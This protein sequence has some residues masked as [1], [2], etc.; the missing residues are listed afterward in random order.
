MWSSS[1]LCR[2]PVLQLQ[3]AG[4]TN[5]RLR[6][7]MDKMAERRAELEAQVAQLK[8]QVRGLHVYGVGWSEFWCELTTV[9]LL[10][11]QG[12]GTGMHGLAVRPMPRFPT[13][14]SIQEGYSGCSFP[15]IVL[16]WPSS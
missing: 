6:T 16:L 9:C 4:E 7:R 8:E 1:R 5:A 15:F 11:G 3:L 13:F 10:L 14:R 2:A 12:A